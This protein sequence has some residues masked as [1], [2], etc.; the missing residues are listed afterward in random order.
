[1]W[2]R[3]LFIWKHSSRV[4]KNLSGLNCHPLLQKVKLALE[5]VHWVTSQKKRIRGD[6]TE[7]KWV[8]SGPGLGELSD[9][10]VS[11]VAREWGHWREKGKSPG[12]VTRR[13]CSQGG[14]HPGFSKATLTGKESQLSLEC[15]SITCPNSNKS[16][17]NSWCC[18]E[19]VGI[20]KFTNRNL[21]L[22]LEK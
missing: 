2:H 14:L 7:R 8:L 16:P 3:S 1:M 20:L 5:L 6:D 10:E 15:L 11:S 12:G 4:W 17:V 9:R 22:T 13:S 21:S 19:G 18:W